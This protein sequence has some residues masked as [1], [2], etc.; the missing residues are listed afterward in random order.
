MH[1]RLDG[2]PHTG[3]AD[4]PRTADVQGSKWC[5]I[6]SHH[7]VA[8][9]F[10]LVQ[11]VPQPGGSLVHLFEGPGRQAALEEPLKAQV[12]DHF[13]YRRQKR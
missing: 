13:G 1:P 3:R 8:S 7:L 9:A 5:A 11:E 4:R 10:P 2:Q 12:R 6:S